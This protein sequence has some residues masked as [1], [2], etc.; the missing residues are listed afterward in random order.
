MILSIVYI[1]L[2]CLLPFALIGIDD[3]DEMQFSFVVKE[4]WIKTKTKA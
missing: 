3:I 2:Q 4:S 1:L